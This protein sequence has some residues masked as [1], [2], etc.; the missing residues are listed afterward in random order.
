MTAD[1]TT[2]A[3]TVFDASDTNGD[4]RIS[5]EKFRSGRPA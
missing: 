3:E 1:V 5:P 4:G 2:T